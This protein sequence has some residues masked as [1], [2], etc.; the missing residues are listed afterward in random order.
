MTELTPLLQ[1]QGMPEN[2][3]YGVADVEEHTTYVDALM[4]EHKTV[5]VKRVDRDTKEVSSVEVAKDETYLFSVHPHLTDDQSTLEVYDGSAKACEA[6]GAFLLELAGSPAEGQEQRMLVEPFMVDLL[7][8]FRR[9][10]EILGE[11]HLVQAR[12][13][14]YP[15]DET[16]LA[17]GAYSPKFKTSQDGY[18]F[19]EGLDEDSEVVSIKVAWKYGKRKVNLTITPNAAFQFSCKDEDEDRVREA[20][21]VLVGVPR[22]LPQLKIEAFTSQK[23]AA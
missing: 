5:N 19:L 3:K 6:V 23:K 9:L 14:N 21:R 10:Q 20:L 18:E 7:V 11:A 15:A 16:D 8:G 13:K 22:R 12:I 4:V 1:A 2:E 17:M